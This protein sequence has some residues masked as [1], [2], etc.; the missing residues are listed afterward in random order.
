MIEA[1]VPHK[2]DPTDCTATSA[3][4]TAET[5]PHAP[6]MENLVETRKKQY[7]IVQQLSAMLGMLSGEPIPDEAAQEWRGLVELTEQIADANDA[8]AR[9][10]KECRELIGA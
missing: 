1:Y 2:S 8:I 10:V 3:P 9:L 6:A 5:L 7:E 4:R